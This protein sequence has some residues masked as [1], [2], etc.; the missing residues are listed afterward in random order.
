MEL[1]TTVK[2]FAEKIR[3]FLP[4]DIYIR[5]IID[6]YDN[7]KIADIVRENIL[8]TIT[9]EEQRR[10]LNLMPDEYQPEGSEEIIKIIEAS[11]L[12]TDIVNLE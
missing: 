7:K 8:T 5:V 2:D 1:R 4:P 9:H 3:N 10:L 12:N 11:H 6:N